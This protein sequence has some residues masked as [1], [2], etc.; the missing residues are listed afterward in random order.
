M[1]DRVFVPNLSP[2]IKHVMIEAHGKCTKVAIRA[3]DQ[4][5]FISQPSASCM[6]HLRC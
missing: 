3:S 6:E 5:I 1:A 4:R 2:N